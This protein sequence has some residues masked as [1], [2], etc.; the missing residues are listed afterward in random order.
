MPFRKFGCFV[1]HSQVH[2]NIKWKDY[3]VGQ[4]TWEPIE[5]LSC[6]EL[7][8]EFESNRKKRGRP[9]KVSIPSVELCFLLQ[10]II[11]LAYHW[12]VH[13]NV[14]S[15]TNTIAMQTNSVANGERKNSKKKTK[16][17]CNRFNEFVFL[18]NLCGV[19]LFFSLHSCVNCVF[20]LS[21][22][23]HD[24]GIQINWNAFLFHSERR[25]NRNRLRCRMQK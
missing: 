11:N 19:A 25:I 6:A 23:C 21:Q 16:I 14:N 18:V 2:Y 1:T 3:P 15:V 12:Y 4:N 5:N 13:S 7:I 10:S 8:K 20:Y 17:K 9:P 24:F 22:I